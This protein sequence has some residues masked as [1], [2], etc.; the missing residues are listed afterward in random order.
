MYI[1]IIP[2]LY[3]SLIICET[4]HSFLL[5]SVLCALSHLTSHTHN[6]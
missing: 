3:G 2:I 4:H 6:L 5:C 1:N